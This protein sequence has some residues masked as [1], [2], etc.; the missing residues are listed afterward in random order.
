MKEKFVFLEKNAILRQYK[1]RSC[2]GL[3]ADKKRI[4]TFR[5]GLKKQTKD[6]ILK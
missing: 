2:G 5:P 4:P 6:T 3:P 1:T